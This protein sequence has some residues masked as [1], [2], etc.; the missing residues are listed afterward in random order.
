MLLSI[1]IHISFLQFQYLSN[2]DSAE[3]MQIVDPIDTTNYQKYLF[4]TT[5]SQQNYTRKF[6]VDVL[7]NGISEISK[8]KFSG[9]MIHCLTTLKNYYQAVVK[10]HELWALKMYDASSGTP[11]GFLTGNIQEMG[12]YDECVEIIQR[13]N[14]FVGQYCIIKLNDTSSPLQHH[15][16]LKGFPV[17][18]SLCVPSVC[19]S[20]NIQN[21]INV[22]VKPMNLS[23]SFATEERTCFT[24]NRKPFSISDW[25]AILTFIFIM[26]LCIIATVYELYFQPFSSDKLHGAIIS[27]S[28]HNNGHLLLNVVKN[29]ESMDVLYGLRFLMMVWIIIIH[30]FTELHMSP[31]MGLFQ[32]NSILQDWSRAFVTN[33][34]VC[35][36]TFFVMSG[37]LL[38]YTFLKKINKEKSFDIVKFYLHRYMR[39]TP[40]VAGLVLFYATLSDRLC[41]GPLCTH[42][43]DIIKKPC[44]KNWWASLTYINN[45]YDSE[46]MCAQ[47]TWYTS[48]DMQLFWLSPILLYPLMH[49]PWTMR[50]LLSGL[51]GVSVV[52]SILQPYYNHISAGYFIAGKV[53]NHRSFL[54]NYVYTHTRATSW[55]LGFG[56]GIYLY[57]FRDNPTPI[58]K[59]TIILGWLLSGIAFVGVIF[60]V[61]PFQKE[62][63]IYDPLYDS[64]QQSMHRHMWALASCWL[65]FACATGHGGF[66]NKLLSWGSVFQPLS[67]L[68]Y[69]IYLTN[70]LILNLQ[71]GAQRTPINFT[72]MTR[73]TIAFGDIMGSIF[74]AVL[75]FLLFEAPGCALERVMLGSDKKRKK[76]ADNEKAH[77]Q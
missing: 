57:K 66:L 13:S 11:P 56:L 42:Y 31:A 48:V 51:I 22:G 39:L 53:E 2:A 58:S 32:W 69:C 24:R 45:Y 76:P 18:Y 65:I 26:G 36:D 75:L 1:I 4:M 64:L 7:W 72:D 17:S 77:K 55:L 20:Q 40:A 37:M 16:T 73:I 14:E 9:D 50:Y 23:L 49:H 38:S 63:R 54:E 41:D 67:R 27:F 43:Y 59:E 61:L 60:S 6:I 74:S 8:N 15:I 30:R 62:N 71:M 33:G 70:M 19:S 5:I 10:T 21:I 47:Q 46:N 44:V 35:V 68:S 29:H 12:S 52:I 3:L 34:F 25:F 28:L